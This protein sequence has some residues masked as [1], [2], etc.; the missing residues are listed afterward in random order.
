MLQAQ[1]IYSRLRKRKGF[2]HKLASEISAAFSHPLNTGRLATQLSRFACW[3]LGSWLAPHPTIVDFVNGSRLILTPEMLMSHGIMAVGLY[4]FEEMSFVLHMLRPE[5]LFVDVGANIGVYTVLAGAASHARCIS[6]EPVPKTY[7]Q[8]LDNININCIRDLV[9]ALNI[10]VG[11]R[12]RCAKFTSALDAMNHIATK[13]D[14]ADELE[15]VEVPLR[16]LDDVLAGT[17]PKVIK[18]DVEGYEPAVIAGARMTL[19]DKG[20][21]AVILETDRPDENHEDANEQLNRE[22]LQLGFVPCT[23]SPFDRQ[24][25]P[26]SNQYPPTRN[27]LFIRDVAVAASRVASAPPFS[28]NGLMV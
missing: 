25:A 2:L 21:L 18:I 28:I 7:S 24:L 16:R 22:M 23:Y 3:E 17:A 27:T 1:K 14:F 11:Y 13:F 20:V 10:G 15:T 9:N 6:I 12:N 4:E 8:L 19:L 5:D 26:I